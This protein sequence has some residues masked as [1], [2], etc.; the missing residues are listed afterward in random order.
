MKTGIYKM[1]FKLR[2]NNWVS[3]I[4]YLC[5][6]CFH[7]QSFLTEPNSRSIFIF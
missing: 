4:L 7:G 5:I 6:K 2:R 1:L 3:A